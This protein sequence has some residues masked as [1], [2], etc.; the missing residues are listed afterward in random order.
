MSS[1]HSPLAEFAGQPGHRL[2]DAQELIDVRLRVLR[3][4]ARARVLGDEVT[5]AREGRTAN[6]EYD[7]RNRSFHASP[8][9]ILSDE[10]RASFIPPPPS[11]QYVKRAFMKISLAP[12]AG[13]PNFVS[14]SPRNTNAPTDSSVA[15]QTAQAICGN[16]TAV[17]LRIFVS[18][19]RN[20]ERA[21]ET[22]QQ[23]V[24]EQF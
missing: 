10:N 9:D 2:G 21:E 4:G 17:N 14:R 12:A 3:I 24:R 11:R 20:L 15:S 6:S 23:L 1:T 7:D 5:P 22:D 8:H 16:S 18:H 19:L 13:S